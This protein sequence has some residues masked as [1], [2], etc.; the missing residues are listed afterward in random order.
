MRD[1][2]D[3]MVYLQTHS[4]SRHE[5]LHNQY[6]KVKE[7]EDQWQDVSHANPHKNA[8]TC[9]LDVFT[10]SLRLYAGFGTLEKSETKCLSGSDQKGGGEEDDGE[11]DVH[12]WRIWPSQEEHQNLQ[13]DCRGKVRDFLLSIL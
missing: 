7:E 9:N 6:N 11:A 1:E 4:Q 13:R 2:E 8:C 5:R 10:F 12:G 3:E